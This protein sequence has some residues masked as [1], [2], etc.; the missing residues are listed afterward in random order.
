M[1]AGDYDAD[2]SLRIIAYYGREIERL[3]RM[4]DHQVADL[5]ERYHIIEKLEQIDQR[6]SHFIDRAQKRVEWHERGLEAFLSMS[7]KQKMTFINGSIGF[8]QNPPRLEVEDG[9]AL[10]AWVDE[11]PKERLRF[12]RMSPDK[13]K[14]KELVKTTGEEPP[15]VC[16]VHGVKSFTYKAQSS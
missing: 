12:F 6:A 13:A 2:R 4:R 5:L 1:V 16:F 3:K 15:G 7:G 10:S 8:R 9:D 14:I 11:D